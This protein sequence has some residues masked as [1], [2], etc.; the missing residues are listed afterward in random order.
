MKSLLRE[1]YRRVKHYD[2][3]P[4]NI[5]HDDLFLVEFPKSGITWLSFLLANIIQ[6]KSNKEFKI[7]FFNFSQ[8][9]SDINYSKYIHLQNNFLP[10]R[11]IKSHANYNPFYNHVVFLIRNPFNVMMSYYSYLTSLGVINTN[12]NSFLKHKKFG[13]NSWKKHT[14]SWLIKNARG[15]VYLVRYEDLLNNPFKTITDLTDILGWEVEKQITEQAI[16]LSSFSEMKK[17][18]QKY[19]DKNPKYNLT[20]VRKG[21]L[22]TK[23]MDSE[24]YNYIFENCKDIIFKFWNDLDFKEVI[25]VK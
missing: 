8:F 23:S 17:D 7:N 22:G 24:S 19:A 15:R 25:S 18:E 21:K 11:I 20:F 16:E 4:Q 10:Y 12:F 14:E 9:I 13:L 2:S 1:L 3:T 5:R 6:K